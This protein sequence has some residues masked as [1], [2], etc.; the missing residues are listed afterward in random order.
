MTNVSMVSGSSGETFKAGP[1]QIRVLEDG[2][3]T[4]NPTRRGHD[5][6]TAKGRSDPA[7]S[8]SHAR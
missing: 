6:R 7:S 3:H 8:S 4:H 5:H 1:I 2:S